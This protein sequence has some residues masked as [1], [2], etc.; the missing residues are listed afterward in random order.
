MRRLAEALEPHGLIACGGFVFG[1]DDD[2]P[3]GLSGA[4]AHAIVLIGHGGGTIWP[5]FTTW[6]DGQAEPPADPLDA[7]SRE[8]IGGVARWLGARAVFPFEKPWLPFQRWAMRA[9]G[10]RPSPLGILMHP[11]FGLWHAYRG[12]LLFDAEIA[13]EAPANPIHLCDL[14]AEKD[15]MN[16]CPAQAVSGRGI[17]AGTC[18]A[19]LRSRAGETCRP[20][21]CVARAACPHD[22]YRYSDEQIAFHMAAHLR[23]LSAS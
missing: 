2:A 18:H 11:Q 8:A 14:C 19:W 12:A 23:G 7:W 1:E 6:L 4:P 10:L 3:A 15:C 13:V 22:D 9:E 20:G 17:D 16:A 21:G 5:H